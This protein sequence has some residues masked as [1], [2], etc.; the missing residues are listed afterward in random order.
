[1][2]TTSLDG[3]SSLASFSDQ[4]EGAVLLPESIFLSQIEKKMSRG[5]FSMAINRL[6]SMVF[7]RMTILLC[8]SSDVLLFTATDK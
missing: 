8:S 6:L 5:I 4:D 7:G 1:M 2:T 3:S